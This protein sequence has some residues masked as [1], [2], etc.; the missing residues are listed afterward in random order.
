[1]KRI[2]KRLGVGKYGQ[3]SNPDLSY[4]IQIRVKAELAFQLFPSQR[5]RK[6]KQAASTSSPKC[7]EQPL[8]SVFIP[9]MSG[10]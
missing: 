4:T 3:H 6:P 7:E 1:M 10:I 2:P 8:G 9:R 5:K